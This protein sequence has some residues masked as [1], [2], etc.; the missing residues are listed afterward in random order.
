METEINNTVERRG[1]S[2]DLMTSSTSGN[3]A[4]AAAKQTRDHHCPI[5]LG[6]RVLL[7]KVNATS[8]Q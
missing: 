6:A 4:A 8:L 7:H 5:G 3:R 1:A 2:G